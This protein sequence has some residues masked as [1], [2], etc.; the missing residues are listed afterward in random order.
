[1]NAD[2]GIA[3]NIGH[4]FSS[5]VSALCLARFSMWRSYY[6]AAFCHSL[7]SQFAYIIY[8]QLL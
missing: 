3:L 2:N 6:N 7:A 1:M 8:L 5:Q 4:L